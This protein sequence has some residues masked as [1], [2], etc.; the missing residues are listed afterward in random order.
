MESSQSHHEILPEWI[1]LG[2]EHFVTGAAKPHGSPRLLGRRLARSPGNAAHSAQRTPARRRRLSGTVA[3]PIVLALI[4]A[5]HV[6][7]LSPVAS[8]FP[9]I[10]A[11]HNCSGVAVR[12]G[13]NLHRKIANGRAQTYCLASGTYDLG[14]K[15]LRPDSGD[16]IVGQR[17]TFGSKGKVTA[18]TKIYGTSTDGVIQGAHSNMSLRLKNLDIC[19]SPRSDITSSGRGVNGNAETLVKLIVRNSRIHN[20]ASAGIGGV[21]QGLV[22]K[23]SEIDH[24]GSGNGGLDAGIKTVSYAVVRDSYIHHNNVLGMWWDCDAPGGIIE[25]SRI[26]ANARTGVEVEIS[27]GDSGSPRPLPPGASY[28]FSIR[29]NRILGNNTSNT[30]GHAG[31]LIESSTNVGVGSNTVIRNQWQEIRVGVGSRAGQGHNSCSSGFYLDAVAITNNDYGPLDIGGCDESGVSCSGN[32][33][34]L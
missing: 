20:N 8:S 21:G 9:A 1:T 29:N 27:S 25:N 28:G 34:I 16:V 15:P 31:I 7:P 3:F 32:R 17:V 6:G 2:E 12:S 33:K 18:P 13:A 22:V 24:N 26:E 30:S 5:L 10:F 14:S 23:N 11:R 4:A 19:C